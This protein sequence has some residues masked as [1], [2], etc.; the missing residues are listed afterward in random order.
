MVL[1]H[2]LPPYTSRVLCFTAELVRELEVYLSIVMEPNR[3]F[4]DTWSG[5]KVAVQK[6]FML[7]LPWKHVTGFRDDLFIHFPVD[8]FSRLRRSEP[9]IVF[10]YELGFR[11]MVSAVY[12]KL[13]R[14]KL[15]LCVCVS[16]HTEQGRGLLRGLVRRWLLKAADAVTYNGPSCLRYLQRFN[17]PAKKLYHFPYA[18]SDLFHFQG[19]IER[20]PTHE[21][22]LLYLGQMTQRKGIVPMLDALIEYCTARPERIVEL[23]CIGTG[24]AEEHVRDRKLP[25]NL[26]L[27]LLGHMQYDQISQAMQQAGILIFPT[28]ADEWGLVV[29]EAMHAGMPVLGSVYAQACT[30]LIRPGENGWLYRPDASN[31]LAQQLDAVYSCSPETINRMRHSARQT[32]A[33]ITPQYV[34]QQAR[35]MFEALRQ[36]PPAAKAR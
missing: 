22:R 15:A 5:L 4:G 19:A 30:T 29:N 34:A 14:R 6:S 21:F 20:D 12:C 27:R 26:R 33:D 3:A 18:A 23:D 16:E 35:K 32:V 1:T 10:S 9:D 8:T 2:Y 24:P 28:L 31:A 36:Q 7:R 13:Y 17:V 25:A 11:S